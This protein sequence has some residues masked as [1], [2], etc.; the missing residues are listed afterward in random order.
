MLGCALPGALPG[1]AGGVIRKACG[2]RA[3]N[4]LRLLHVLAGR[5]GVAWRGQT[6]S[7]EVSRR[8]PRCC[9]MGGWTGAV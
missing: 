5:R 3:G 7:G 4:R 2:G 8:V 1:C 6:W 9:G